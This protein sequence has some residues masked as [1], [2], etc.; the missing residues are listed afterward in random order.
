MLVLLVFVV[1][2]VVAFD[3][4]LVWFNW[5]L[6][7][8]FVVIAAVDRLCVRLCRRRSQFLRK[9]LPQA[10]QWY[11]LISVWVNR[12]VFKLERWLKLR[13]QTGHLCGDSSMCRILWTANVLDWQ[14]PLPHSVHL[15][16][17]SFE[18]IYLLENKKKKIKKNKN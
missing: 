11:G 13:L 8:S 18:W 7:D 9:T 15:N 3:D 16:G 6:D 4:L 5:L 14:N 1:N 17:F 2:V 10:V 12:W